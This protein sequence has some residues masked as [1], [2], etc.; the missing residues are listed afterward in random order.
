MKKNSIDHPFRSSATVH[1]GGRLLR[2]TVDGGKFAVE[3]A[4]HVE[5]LI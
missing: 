1:A 4:G 3:T 2:E 5:S